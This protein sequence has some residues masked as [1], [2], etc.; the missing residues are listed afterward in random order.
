[1]LTAEHMMH[2]VSWHTAWLWQADAKF[3]CSR[4]S[5]Q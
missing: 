5:L 3:A 4:I 2:K 1:L